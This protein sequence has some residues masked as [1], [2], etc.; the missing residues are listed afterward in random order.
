MLFPVKDQS[1]LDKRSLINLR[2]PLGWEQIGNC[3]QGGCGV[4]LVQRPPRQ[5]DAEQR[6]A[7]R[8]PSCGRCQVSPPSSPPCPQR[9]LGKKENISLGKQSASL[10]LRKQRGENRKGYAH[11]AASA[12]FNFLLRMLGCS[13]APPRLKPS[14]CGSGDCHS[15]CQHRPRRWGQTPSAFTSPRTRVGVLGRWE[16]EDRRQEL[17]LRF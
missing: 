6:P 16:C 3:S 17:S 13:V 8:R 5:S 1:K 9:C 10:A 12:L 4:W 15:D 11:S 14:L 7:P 2:I